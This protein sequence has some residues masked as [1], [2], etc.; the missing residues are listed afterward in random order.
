MHNKT[1]LYALFMFCMIFIAPPS[2]AGV[3]Y[4]TRHITTPEKVGDGS[5]Y[6]ALWK[7]YD[8]ALYTDDGIWDGKAPFALHIVYDHDVKGVRIAETSIE[9]IKRQGFEDSDTLNR[10]YERLKEIFPDVQKG[11]ELTGVL[12]KEGISHFYNEDK[13]LGSVKDKNFGLYFFNIWLGQNTR[14][15]ELRKNLIEAG[16]NNG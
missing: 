16:T 12:D 4:I 3:D 13:Y 9:E 10:W 7:F 11:S 15:P 6:Y 2:Y 5:F 8:I 14:E 1:S